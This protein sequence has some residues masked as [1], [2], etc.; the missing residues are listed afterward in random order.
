MA[1]LR[2]QEA[3]KCMIGDN[4]YLHQWRLD[5]KKQLSPL[6]T[7]CW[8]QIERCSSIFTNSGS[9]INVH[10]STIRIFMFLY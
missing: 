4:H 1:L 8:A 2:E 3:S 7:S 5:G 10:F 6:S 9:K